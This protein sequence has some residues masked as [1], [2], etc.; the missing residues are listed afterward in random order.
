M[1]INN[2]V[3]EITEASASV[4]LLLATAVA[5]QI[6]CSHNWLSENKLSVLC[7]SLKGRVLVHL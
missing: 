3:K 1:T 5:K 4:R 7:T 6:R 2:K